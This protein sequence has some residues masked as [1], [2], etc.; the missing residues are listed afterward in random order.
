MS[1]G[2]PN[3]PAA[4]VPLSTDFCADDADVIIRAAGTID[5]RTHKLILSLVS[6]IF[7]DMFTLPQPPS[8]TPDT[9]PRVNVQDSTKTWEL[10]LKTI[11]PT[12][13]NPTIDTLDDLESL[14]FAAQVYEMQSIIETHKKTFEHQAFIRK[15][16][17]RLYALACACGFEDQATY[18]ARNAKL[19]TVTRRSDPNNLKGLAFGAYCRLVSFLAERDDEWHRTLGDVGTPKCGGGC[20]LQPET[21]NLLYNDIKKNLRQPYLKEEEVYL[22]AL[23][24]RSRFGQSGCSMRSCPF[25]DSNIKG[26][27][28]SRIEERGKVCDKFQPA[29]WYCKPATTLCP[30]PI[31]IISIRFT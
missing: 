19:L 24:C 8:T 7:K 9:L 18:V 14:L 20:I 25:R 15:D 5:F 16:P 22:K 1:S 10:I 13:P 4:T 17:L 11:Y 29:K 26:F 3:E 2:K 30:D 31:D 23:E 27:I 12:L 6:P 21:A 28:R